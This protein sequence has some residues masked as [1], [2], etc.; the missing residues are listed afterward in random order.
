[1]S[2]ESI[3]IEW[4]GSVHAFQMCLQFLNRASWAFGNEDC[5]RFAYSFNESFYEMGV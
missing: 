1:M 2:G 4:S 3:K 5:Q